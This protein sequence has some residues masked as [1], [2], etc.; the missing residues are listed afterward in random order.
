MREGKPVILALCAHPD[1]AEF[2]CGGTLALLSA[3]D[4]EVHI[5]T[6]TAGDCGSTEEPPNVIA[7]RRKVEAAA[8]A[9]CFGG[10]YHWLGG[11]DLQVY[12]DNPT[13]SAATCLIREVDPDCVIT[14]YPV[15]YMIDHE[16]TSSVVRTALFLSPI[17]NYAVGSARAVPPTK[18][19]APLYYFGPFGGTDYFGNQVHPRSY[20]D[21]SSVM[22]KKVEALS[23]HESQREWL[24]RQH[25]IDNYIEEMKSWDA[26]AGHR[27]GV[28]YAEGIFIHK[29]HAYP[30][31]PIL[32]EALAEYVITDGLRT[33]RQGSDLGFGHPL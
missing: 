9:A 20:I 11:Q 17:V 22:D 6:L 16:V 1:D 33:Q 29:G 21:I 15:D 2:C 32:Q 3:R 14:H 30:Q 27:A 4:W 5:A 7:A 19:M 23:C 28:E 24:R 12:D 25:G 18:E 26:E 13:R 8:A 10:T 31:T